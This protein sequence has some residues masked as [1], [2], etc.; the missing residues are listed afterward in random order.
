M[1]TFFVICFLYSTHSQIFFSSFLSIGWLLA[2]TQIKKFKL[3]K[4]HPSF[5]AYNLIYLFLV[6][7]YYRLVIYLLLGQFH[8]NRNKKKMTNIEDLCFWVITWNFLNIEH[9]SKMKIG[10][11]ILNSW[12]ILDWEKIWSSKIFSVQSAW[13]MKNWSH[14]CLVSSIILRK[15]WQ[16]QS[17][18]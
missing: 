6:H 12:N 10:L 14:E 5:R 13:E 16:M 4:L 17:I 1:Y 7:A 8:W 3:F 9:S 18:F 2:F 15:W 11:L